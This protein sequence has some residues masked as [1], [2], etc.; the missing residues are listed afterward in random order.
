MKALR[1]IK[2]EKMRTV[3]IRQRIA[4]VNTLGVYRLWWIQRDEGVVTLAANYCFK[5]YSYVFIMRGFQTV[6]FDGILATM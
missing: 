2:G 3:L 4:T 5:D 1:V 6:I